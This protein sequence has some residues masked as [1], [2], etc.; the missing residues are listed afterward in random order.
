MGRFAFLNYLIHTVALARCQ[1]E[2]P[3]PGIVLTVSLR[4]YALGTDQT[5]ETVREIRGLKLYHRA[6]AA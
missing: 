5:V 6:K 1:N 3:T 4:R 2:L